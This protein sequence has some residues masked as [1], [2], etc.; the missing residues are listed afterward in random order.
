MK[1]DIDRT[2][3]IKET[4]NEE[5]IGKDMDFIKSL[6]INTITLESRANNENVFYKWAHPFKKELKIKRLLIAK[7]YKENGGVISNAILKNN[8]PS[9]DKY[10]GVVRL[11]KTDG[12]EIYKA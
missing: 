8:L 9:K 11:V 2:I 6:L 7:Y 3:R 1:T 10:P 5:F 12:F 4:L